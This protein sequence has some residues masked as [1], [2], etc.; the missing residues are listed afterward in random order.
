MAMKRR[1]RPARQQRSVTA[2]ELL[3]VAR[4]R[5]TQAPDVEP[6]ALLLV[7]ASGLKCVVREALGEFLEHLKNAAGATTDAELQTIEEVAG[8][9]RCSPATVRRYIGTGRLRTVRTGHGGSGRV[10]IPRA[11]LDAFIRDSQA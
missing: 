11:E 9:L 3:H 5:G 8:E 2:G 4:E 6:T 1:H 10:L 7:S